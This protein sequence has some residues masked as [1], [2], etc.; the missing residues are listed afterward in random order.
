MSRPVLVVLLLTFVAL[1]AA[2]L[3]VPKRF[4]QN[5][6][7]TASSLNVLGYPGNAGVS[8]R[9]WRIGPAQLGATPPRIWTWAWD[10]R[11]HSG[12]LRT[13]YSGQTLWAIQAVI[14]PKGAVPSWRFMLDWPLWLAT[15][16]IILV[17]GGLLAL[18]LHTRAK[19][20]SVD[21]N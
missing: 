6:D 10:S 17:L 7:L 12:D 9:E 5:W 21:A 18:A 4:A 15:Q 3:W 20:R 16:A 11:L 13:A 2:T 14:T 8:V 19:R 1:V